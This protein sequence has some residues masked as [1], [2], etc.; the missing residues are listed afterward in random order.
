LSLQLSIQLLLSLLFFLLIPGLPLAVF[1]GQKLS[2]PHISLSLAPFFSISTNFVLLYILNFIGIRPSLSFYALVIGLGS[3]V[4][5]VRNCQMVFSAFKAS[6]L[7]I[8]AVIPSMTICFYIWVTSFSEYN[9]VAPNQDAFRHNFWIARIAQIHSVLATDSFV[10]SPL[11]GLGT[12][13]GFY[14]LSWHSAVAVAHSVGAVPIPALSLATTIILW[15]VAL[16]LGLTALATE[17]APR[18]KFLGLVAGVLVQL[19]P[20]VPG[21]PMSWGSMTSI[22][23]ISFLPI[24]FLLVIIAFERRDVFSSLVAMFAFVSLIFIHTPAAATLGVLTVSAF[25]AYLRQFNTRLL[26]KFAFAALVSMIPILIL[27]RSY[28]FG[29]NDE[30]KT[31]WGAVFPFWDHAI[32]SFVTSSVNVPNSPVVL[33]LLFFLGVGFVAYLRINPALLLGLFGIFTVYLI[34]GAPSGFLNELRFLTTPW[35]ASYE[36]T[37]WVAVPFI[38]LI[39]AFPICAL[40]QSPAE[41]SRIKNTLGIVVA[42]LL[43][44]GVV[45]QQVDATTTQLSKGPLLSE[46]VGKNDRLLL[47]RLKETLKEDEIVYTFA[48]DGS[49]YAF[50]YEGILVT[51]GETYNRD[52]EKSVLLE[53]LNNNIHSICASPQAQEAI[54]SEK[55]AAFIFG[56]RLLG[57]GPPGWKKKD[58]EALGGLRLVDSGQYLYVAVPD[59]G[60]CTKVTEANP[61]L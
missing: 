6:L 11:Q 1:V 33:S 52:G 9:F 13:T 39:A 45:R 4:V 51:A 17:I 44:T 7:P 16:P 24:G 14:P 23:G 53:A 55:I 61:G 30:I 46:V 22:I 5:L 21:V 56:G 40:F 29:G 2:R 37:A 12:G 58:I 36:R 18:M 57:W 43:L 26:I 27:F 59:L 10:G 48:N 19:F 15:G 54:A 32:G 31:L 35:Y 3:L 47:Q 34:S 38:A 49:T 20:M 8:V 60:N 42:L 50:M 25:P 41:S 28:I